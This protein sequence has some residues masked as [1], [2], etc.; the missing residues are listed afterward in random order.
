MTA[1]LVVVSCPK[2]TEANAVSTNPM[3]HKS[4]TQLFDSIN[5]RSGG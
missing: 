1:N 4:Y 3:W 2:A 5:E